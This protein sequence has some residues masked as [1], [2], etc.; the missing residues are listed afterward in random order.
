MLEQTSIA[1]LLEI[2]SRVGDRLQRMWPESPAAA[3]TSRRDGLPGAERALSEG[4]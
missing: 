1:D 4:A 3:A 2:E